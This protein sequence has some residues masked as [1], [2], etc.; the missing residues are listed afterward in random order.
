M[1]ASSPPIPRPLK[2][3]IPAGLLRFASNPWGLRAIP[4][5]ADCFFLAVLIWLFLAGATGWKA[6]LMDGDTGWHIRTGEF[7]LDHRLIPDKDI[8]SYSKPGQPWFAWEWLSDVCFAV[9]FRWAGLKG[10]VLFA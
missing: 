8:F 10:V 2:P 6:L 5:F 3:S 7:I 1:A 4:S 9:L